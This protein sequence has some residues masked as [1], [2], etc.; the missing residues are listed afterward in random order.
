VKYPE[1]FERFKAAL[2]ENAAMPPPALRKAT[3]EE[4]H[5]WKQEMRAFDAARLALGLTTA[6]E[7]QRKNAM[8]P[9]QHGRARIVRY[10]PYGRRPAATL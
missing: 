6:A 4:F 7:I 1:A 5:E 2:Q 3:A 8:I 10:A 9:P